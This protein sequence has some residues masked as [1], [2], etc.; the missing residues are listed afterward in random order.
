MRISP[1]L[2]EFRALASQG[3]LISL[4]CELLADTETPVSAYLKLRRNVNS[5]S[6][7]L[8][9]AEFGKSW[10]RYSLI[11][12]DPFLLV[13]IYSERTEVFNGPS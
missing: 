5:F 7:L 11:G 6:F 12:L 3:N 8:E 9:S 4:Y 10:G 13:L 1:S 2:D